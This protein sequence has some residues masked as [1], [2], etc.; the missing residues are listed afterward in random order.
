M[1]QIVEVGN[2]HC[3][4]QLRGME[5]K[6]TYCQERELEA[7]KR[8]TPWDS[9]NMCNHECICMPSLLNIRNMLWLQS[10]SWETINDALPVRSYNIMMTAAGAMVGSYAMQAT[11]IKYYVSA[12][13]YYMV[14]SP[15]LQEWIE[16]E[17]I[18]NHLDHYD[19]NT[20]DLDPYFSENTDLDYDPDRNGVSLLSFNREYGKWVR[21]CLAQATGDPNG[22]SVPLP[23]GSPILKLAYAISLVARRALAVSGNQSAASDNF[24]DRFHMLFKGDIRITST[25]DEWVFGDMTL[26]EVV[27]NGVRMALRL[28]ADHFSVEE[29]PDSDELYETIEMYDSTMCICH[30]SDPQ[31]KRSILTDSKN[32]VTL[33]RQVQEDFYSDEPVYKFYLLMMELRTVYY[34]VVKLNKESVRGLWSGQQHELIF[35]GNDESE[36]GSIQQ[37]RACARNLVNQSCDLPVGYPI[38]VSP[39]TTAYLD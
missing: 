34:Q 27:K 5:F 15:Q 32:L 35:L 13:I 10:N 25:N 2:G 7:I 9:S 36:R 39:L 12:T 23:L 26:L 38:F 17:V 4:F 33:R 22:E 31:W 29:Y 37:M 14:G 19:T 24:M 8:G 6:G 21:Y 18:S 11:M 3:T 28:H 30:E 20:I 1:V 16:N